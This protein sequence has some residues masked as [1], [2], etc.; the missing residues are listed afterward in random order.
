MRIGKLVQ[1][2]QSIPISKEAA[3][4]IP[5]AVGLAFFLHLWLTNHST[6]SDDSTH[7]VDSETILVS[8]DSQS[9][10]K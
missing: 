7:I 3:K 5:R 10:N 8:S 2:V 4:K 6:N 1:L 9:I